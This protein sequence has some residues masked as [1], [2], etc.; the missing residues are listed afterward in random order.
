MLSK[1]WK[2]QQ[3]LVAK[4]GTGFFQD[5][6]KSNFTA[7]CLNTFVAH[8]S[9]NARRLIDYWTDYDARSFQ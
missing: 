7:K 5:A 3:C 1:K 8:C 4:R 2:N 6:Q 9:Y